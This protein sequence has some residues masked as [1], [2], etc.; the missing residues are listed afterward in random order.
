M[1][2]VCLFWLFKPLKT[3]RVVLHFFRTFSCIMKL[4]GPA[5][6]YNVNGDVSLVAWML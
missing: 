2:T 3:A 1:R 6:G 5:S 4:A